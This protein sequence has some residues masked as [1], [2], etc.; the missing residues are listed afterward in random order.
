VSGRLSP[1]QR[2]IATLVAA[3]L[4]DKQIAARLGIHEGTVGHHVGLIA[5]VWRLN[6]TLNLRIQITHRVIDSA[7]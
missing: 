7:A 5:K 2:I 3:G 6:P 4:S 1:R